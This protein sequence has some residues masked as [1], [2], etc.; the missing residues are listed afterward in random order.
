MIS[1]DEKL[2]SDATE[3]RNKEKLSEN[4]FE[5][6]NKSSIAVQANDYEIERRSGVLPARR[7]IIPAKFRY[8]RT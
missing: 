5:G 4:Q 1:V 2:L 8:L 3:G 7:R 6:D